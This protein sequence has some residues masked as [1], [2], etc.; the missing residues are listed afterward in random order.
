M[1]RRDAGTILSQAQ[2]ITA[3]SQS[4]S[5]WID[6]FDPSHQIAQVVAL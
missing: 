5:Y 3:L 4:S 6:F 1:A 2:A